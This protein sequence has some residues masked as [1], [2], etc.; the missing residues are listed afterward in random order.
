MLRREGEIFSFPADS[1]LS[2]HT[3]Y[4]NEFVP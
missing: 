1:I 4:S 3:I 2:S